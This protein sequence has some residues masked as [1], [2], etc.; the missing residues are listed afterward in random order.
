M[1][2]FATIAVAIVAFILT[3]TVGYA[4]RDSRAPDCNE[5]VDGF[6]WIIMFMS[7]IVWIVAGYFLLAAAG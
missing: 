2:W 4:A 5:E 7:V 6:K 3:V 1:M